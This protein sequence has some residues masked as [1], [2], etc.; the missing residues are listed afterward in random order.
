MSLS[1]DSLFV[2][3]AVAVALAFVGFSLFRSLKGKPSS[4]CS[5]PDPRAPGGQAASG[6]SS[7][8]GCALR[9]KRD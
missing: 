8:P 5:S 4:C 3:A 1:F 2:A 7:C 6:C 9:P